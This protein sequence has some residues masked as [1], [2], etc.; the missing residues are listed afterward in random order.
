MHQNENAKR[1]PKMSK[2]QPV[3]KVSYPK[4]KKGQG[5]AQ[6]V[7]EDLTFSKKHTTIFTGILL[8][9]FQTFY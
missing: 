6:P 9:T 1:R 4:Y 7:L 2:G 8:F 5:N 3:F